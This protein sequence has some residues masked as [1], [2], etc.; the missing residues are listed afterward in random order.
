MDCVTHRYKLEDVQQALGYV[1]AGKAVKA[2]I[3]PQDSEEN[4]GIQNENRIHRTEKRG[5]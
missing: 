5:R 2:A 4:S 3:Y 1:R